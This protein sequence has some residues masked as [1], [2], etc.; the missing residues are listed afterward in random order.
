MALDNEAKFKMEYC[1]FIN[2]LNQLQAGFRIFK[3]DYH[4][5]FLS[6]LQHAFDLNYCYFTAPGFHL[7]INLKPYSLELIENKNG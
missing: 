6:F 5:L 7:K 2:T 4:V 1:E 3:R